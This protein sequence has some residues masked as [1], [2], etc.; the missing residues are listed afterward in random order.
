MKN[1]FE[2][3]VGLFWGAALFIG[4]LVSVVLGFNGNMRSDWIP[5]VL[6]GAC[7]FLIMGLLFHGI[8]VLVKKDK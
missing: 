8:I 6:I 7:V 5:S 4:A 1:K 3:A 2:E